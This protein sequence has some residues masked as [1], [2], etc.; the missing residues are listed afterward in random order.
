MSI[1]KETAAICSATLALCL[2]GACSIPSAPHRSGSPEEYPDVQAS[3]PGK[4]TCL[5]TTDADNAAAAKATSLARARSGLPPVTP[6]PVLGRAAASHACDM[7]RRG[8]MAHYGTTT[9]GPGQRVKALG[10]RPRL[11][12]ENIA[13]GPFNLTSVLSTWNSSHGHLNNIMIPQIREVGIGR[14]IGSDR[15]TVFWSAVYGAPR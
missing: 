10:Y 6:N 5:A 8:L 15:K 13:A 14:A 4:A 12:A 1:F 7:A 11:T 2:L 3:A 9:T